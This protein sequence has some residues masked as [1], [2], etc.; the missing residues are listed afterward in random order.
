MLEAVVVGDA[1]EGFHLGLILTAFAFGLRHGI[2]WDHIAAI[3]DITSSQAGRKSIRLATLYVLGH[4]LVV[5]MLGLVAIELGTVLPAG[6][7]SILERVV[8]LTLVLLGSYVLY[9]LLRYKRDFRMRSRWM[10]L[11]S[12]TRRLVRYMRSWRE[13]SNAPEVIEHEHEHDHADPLHAA[14]SDDK[15]LGRNGGVVTKIRS[16]RHRH[17]HIGSMPDDPFME[18]GP[19][20]SWVVGMIHGIG[21]ETPTQLLV[22][23]VAVQAG[24]RVAG[25][26]LLAAFV[27]G[28]ILS[29]TLIALASTF[30]FLRAGRNFYAY[31]SVAVLVGCFSLVLGALF[32]FG[33]GS[34]MPAIF[35]G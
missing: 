10:L 27:G 9:G 22:F 30:G 6:I 26:T 5:F 25:A 16:H 19:A 7:D 23:L 33:R 17:R 2:D 4:A 35:G 12:G 14:H 29:N 34:V 8:G 15:V 11:F 24:G 1:Q 32:L 18:Y 3:A 13:V 28:L 21:A 31:A 20:T